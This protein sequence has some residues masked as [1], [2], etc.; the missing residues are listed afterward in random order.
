MRASDTER[1]LLAAIV[2]H[3]DEDT[4]RLAF[5]DLLDERGDVP[6]NERAAFIRFQ[7]Q[8]ERDLAALSG[9]D[10]IDAE[11]RQFWTDSERRRYGYQPPTVRVGRKKPQPV[12]PT[13]FDQA[14]E[15]LERHEEGW[16]EPFDPWLRR[17]SDATMESAY[18]NFRRGFLHRFTMRVDGFRKHAAK[19]FAK[20][21]VVE[22]WFP[23]EGDQCGKLADRKE[24]THVR[25]LDLRDHHATPGTEDGI[26][27]LLLSPHLAGL[28]R[29]TTNGPATNGPEP[30]DLR[31]LLKARHLTK[32][33]ALHLDSHVQD[34]FLRA[35]ATT[36]KLPALTTLLVPQATIEPDTAAAL[37]DSPGLAAL[38]L[39]DL[40]DAR[41]SPRA[42]RRLQ[43]RFGA[44]VRFRKTR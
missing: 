35:L 14:Q 21:P 17:Y 11:W 26:E 42:K 24:L 23:E 9:W 22:L 31:A 28:R 8:A 6:S 10:R 16:I 37:A 15:L 13:A 36:A 5:A 30:I 20:A 2:A 33:E 1:A 27:E 7:I 19:L 12:P 29:L 39:L 43:E 41:V 4:P 44:G 38:R 18:F 3:P 25:S 40:S 32:L 34:E